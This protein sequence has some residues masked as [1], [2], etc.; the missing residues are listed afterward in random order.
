MY[1][2]TRLLWTTWSYC[3]SITIGINPLLSEWFYNIKLE[4]VLVHVCVC[5]FCSRCVIHLHVM[6]KN[7]ALRLPVMLHYFGKKKQVTNPS[8]LSYWYF[9]SVLV[10]EGFYIIHYFWQNAHP[11]TNDR[12]IHFGNLP[13]MSFLSQI[14]FLF[15]KLKS[16]VLIQYVHVHVW[17]IPH[18]WV[19][20][21]APP[22]KKKHPNK[23]MK[24]N[25]N[26]K[27]NVEKQGVWVPLMVFQSFCIFTWISFQNVFPWK[28]FGN[29]PFIFKWPPKFWNAGKLGKCSPLP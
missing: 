1:L 6:M 17:S 18:W 13:E 29:I 11:Y 20:C 10:S 7:T 22:P 5:I 4:F 23:W 15:P 24:K 19:P 21:N 8:N 25:N 9:Q 2:P 26:P 14:C 12:F 3:L 16:V 27:M 28:L